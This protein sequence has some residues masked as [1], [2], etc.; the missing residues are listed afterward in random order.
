MYTYDDLSNITSDAHKSYTYDP[1]NR[2]TNTTTSTGTSLETFTY[3]TSGD[4]T[5]STNTLTP[6]TTYSTNT[7]NQYTQTTSSGATTNYTY[8]SNGNIT[9]DGTKSYTYDYKNRLIQASNSW[10][11]LATYTYDVLWRRVSKQTTQLTKYLY[12]NNQLIE[13]NTSS[14][15]KYYVNGLELDDVFKYTIVPTGTG[16][17]QTYYYGKDHLWS[18]TDITSST[19]VL[20]TEYTYD[21]YGTPTIT[22]GT[23][24]WNTRLYTWREFDSETGL[25]YNRARY[26]SPK[27]GRFISRDPIWINDDINL[28]SYTGNNPLNGVDRV[29]LNSK[30]IILSIYADRWHW[31]EVW[32]FH[33]WIEINV[34]RKAT[35]YWFYPIN[36]PYSIWQRWDW[37]KII[38]YSVEWVNKN[39]ETFKKIDTYTD[40]T[41]FS[42]EITKDQYGA[43]MKSIQKDIDNWETWGIKPW[44]YWV[45]SAWASDKWN[46]IFW[47]THYLKDRNRIWASTPN[48][49]ADSIDILKSN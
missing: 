44:N 31:T 3:N 24:I 22:Q 33:S 38:D 1:I 28:Y 7:L 10:W 23:D 13:E 12:A 20:V 40:F 21:T 29:G 14:N 2:L 43:L 26:Y 47:N 16:S 48:T 30:K 8:D 19:W 39:I 27:L 46:E 49:L 17:V 5:Q 35:T 4:R 36:N 25:Y 41:N 42:Q 18:I 37:S 9:S 11:T 6:T 15:N 34:G 32:W 45:C